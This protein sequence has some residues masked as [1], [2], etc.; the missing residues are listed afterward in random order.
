MDLI[1]I[2][3]SPSVK[4]GWE[5]D[6]ICSRHGFPAVEIDWNGDQFQ[7]HLMVFIADGV[8]PV[9]MELTTNYTE[10]MWWQLSHLHCKNQ[11]LSNSMHWWQKTYQITCIFSSYY[12]PKISQHITMSAICPYIHCSKHYNHTVAKFTAS[13]QCWAVM[14]YLLMCY[15]NTFFSVMSIVRDYN[16]K[17]RNDS[18]VTNPSIT[19]LL[20]HFDGLFLPWARWKVDIRLVSHSRSVDRLLP[21]QSLNSPWTCHHTMIFVAMEAKSLTQASV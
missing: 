12:C 10:V 4:G 8:S 15:S 6:V 19:P 7:P 21:E 11:N 14:R 1:C 3:Y 13:V 16:L 2:K 18:T 20:W 17:F 5:K 9:V